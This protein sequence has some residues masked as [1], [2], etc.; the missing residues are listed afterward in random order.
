M[1]GFHWADFIQCSRWWVW[2]ASSIAFITR[3]MFREILPSPQ[4]TTR[5]MT[6]MSGRVASSFMVRP[7]ICTKFSVPEA[8]TT[9]S[10]KRA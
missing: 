1:I 6:T 2:N 7:S 10:T 8:F 9:P 4:G 3:V 5:S